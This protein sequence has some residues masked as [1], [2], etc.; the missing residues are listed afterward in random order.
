MGR[1][2]TVRP[3]WGDHP[4]SDLRQRPTSL[5]RGPRFGGESKW[6]DAGYGSREVSVFWRLCWMSVSGEMSCFAEMVLVLM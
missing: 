5:S 6:R 2:R 3:T 1:P 4:S